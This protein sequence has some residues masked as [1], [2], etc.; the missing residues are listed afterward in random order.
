MFIR[1]RTF[2]AGDLLFDYV[3][4]SSFGL[5]AYLLTKRRPVKAGDSG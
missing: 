4:I 3:G 5:L 2:D 1:S